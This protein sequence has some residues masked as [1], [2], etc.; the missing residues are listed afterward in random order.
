MSNKAIIQWACEY[1][2]S[3]GY[4]LQS[5]LPETVQ[6]TPWSY[7]M[8]FATTDGYIYLKQTPELLALEASIIEILH[9]Q[10]H[11][12]VPEI[13]AKNTELN[14][15][16][17]KDAGQS[18]RVLLKQK[19]D[20]NFLFRAIHQFI[21]LQ[22]A[23]ADHIEVLLDI[24]V[25]DWQ[26]SKLPDL[27]KELL[28]KKDVL[29][30]DG[31]SEDEMNELEALLPKVCDLCK[32]LSG[33]SIKDTLVQPDFNDN[34]SL[35]DVSLQKI[36][37]IDLGEISIA[38]PF[39]SLINLLLVM[40]KHHAITEESDA[41]QRIKNACLENYMKFES[42]ANLLRAFEIAQMLFPI[43]NALAGYRLLNA[44]DKSKFTPPFQRHAKPGA[45]LRDF[46][47]ACR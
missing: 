35:I 19:F 15:F 42:E 12:S 29:I 10:F 14:I 13:I 43:Y 21:S 2:S 28:Y 9:H 44:C 17:M 41:Y 37:I 3:H 46:I 23:V 33:Y 11:A 6:D 25:P 32:K 40:K 39:F 5:N 38:H 7:V 27:Y 45:S 26:L 24:G 22:L 18:L 20:E 1:L 36:T 16:L 34:N 47:T 31:L 30:A 8:R 4:T